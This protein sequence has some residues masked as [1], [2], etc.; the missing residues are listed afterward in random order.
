MLI[1]TFLLMLCLVPAIGM[2]VGSSMMSYFD[3][4]HA[5]RLVAAGG[6]RRPP[7]AILIPRASI[8]RRV[9]G[10]YEA[11]AMARGLALR[12]GRVPPIT[13]PLPA[14]GLGGQRLTGGGSP[15]PG[16]LGAPPVQG[17]L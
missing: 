5:L 9:P 17:V 2:I 6:R 11:H 10:R 8:R 1:L 4:S 7:G 12:T 13:V 14:G 3:P 16:Q 15:V